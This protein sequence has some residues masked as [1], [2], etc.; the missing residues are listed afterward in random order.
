M[1]KI[2]EPCTQKWSVEDI[3]CALENYAEFDGHPSYEFLR[4]CE[5]I[6]VIVAVCTMTREDQLGLVRRLLG[7]EG[8]YDE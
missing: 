3:A 5:P 7:W 8:D 6:D 1:L 2:K 4:Q